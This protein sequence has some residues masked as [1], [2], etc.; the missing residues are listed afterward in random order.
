MDYLLISKIARNMLL[1]VQ[2][3]RGAVRGMSA[4]YLVEGKARVAGRWRPIRGV[5]VGWMR[6]KVREL[7]PP[8]QVVQLMYC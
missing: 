3:Y 2:V 5:A 8:R 6:I 1:D 7:T 4:H